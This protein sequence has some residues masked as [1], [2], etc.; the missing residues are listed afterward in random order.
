MLFD[1]EPTNVYRSIDKVINLQTIKGERKEI[2]TSSYATTAGCRVADPS[3][4]L[5]G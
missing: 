4:I 3:D 1:L 5:G 2:C